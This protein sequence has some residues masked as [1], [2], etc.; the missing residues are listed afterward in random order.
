MHS[1]TLRVCGYVFSGGETKISQKFSGRRIF[2]PKI[3]PE[4]LNRRPVSNE[5]QRCNAQAHIRYRQKLTRL[6]LTLRSLTLYI[7]G[8]PILDVSRSHTTTQHSR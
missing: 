2:S 8:A 6:E 4:N 3:I 5:E 1:N 7:Y